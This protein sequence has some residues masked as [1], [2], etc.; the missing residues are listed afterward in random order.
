VPQRISEAMRRTIIRNASKGMSA[1]ELKRQ[2]ESAKQAGREN[3][4]RRARL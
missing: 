4:E 1:S 3:E 2:L